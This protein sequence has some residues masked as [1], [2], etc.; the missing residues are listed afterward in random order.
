MVTK[1]RSSATRLLDHQLRA[2]RHARAADKAGGGLLL[3]H[4]MGSGKTLTSLHICAK[5]FPNRRITVFAPKHLRSTWMSELAISG[6]SIA[7][8]EVYA[9]ET[10]FTHPPD[11]RGIAIV[12]EAHYLADIIAKEH[13]VFDTLRKFHRT[14]HLTGT[15]FKKGVDELSMYVNIVSKKNLIPGSVSTFQRQF[16]KSLTNPQKAWNNWVVNT[17]AKLLSMSARAKIY[18]EFQKQKTPLQFTFKYLKNELTKYLK[19]GTYGVIIAYMDSFISNLSY[20]PTLNSK[21]LAEATS[22]FI[23]LVTAEDISKSTIPFP[24]VTQVTETFAYTSEQL[25]KFTAMYS[26]TGG[27]VTD[28]NLDDLFGKNVSV[29][30][31]EA[32]SMEYVKKI[33]GQG[34]SVGSESGR[35]SGWYKRTVPR[36]FKYIATICKSSTRIVMYSSFGEVSRRLFAYLESE[37]LGHRVQNTLASYPNINIDSVQRNF[38]GSQDIILLHPKLQEGI[39]IKGTSKLI[40]VEPFSD[41]SAKQQVEARVVRMGSHARF[42]HNSVEIITCVTGITNTDHTKT[43]FSFVEN[44]QSMMSDFQVQMQL[45]KK[46]LGSLLTT[47]PWIAMGDMDHAF[48]GPEISQM[49]ATKQTEEQLFS[50]IRSVKTMLGRNG[51]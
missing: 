24:F 13:V 10:L 9:H 32:A 51:G 21:K 50:F 5:L 33:V 39:S 40:I 48:P 42:K 12:D 34:Y 46:A 29:I 8:V 11:P 14:Y 2:I 23:N 35:L 18:Y 45:S 30:Q 31:R 17:F 43:K 38:E 7:S 22:E 1:K 15:P 49:I 20:K 6:V 4:V 27:Q 16:T 36:K 28:A 44:L 3:F 26:K 47:P 37:G 25:S 19:F 41:I